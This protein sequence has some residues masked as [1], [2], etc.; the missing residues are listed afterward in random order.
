MSRPRN[1]VPKFS[2]DNT[3]RAF[4]KVG[5]RFISLGRADLPEALLRFAKVLEDHAKGLPVETAQ[6]PAKQRLHNITD[7]L[8]L[9]V[10]KE[11]PRFSPSERHCQAAA[12]RVLRKLFGETPVDQFGPLRL[13][14]VRDAMIA[15]D[16]N[17]TDSDGN[18][19]HRKPWA[20]DTVNRQVKRLQ[21]IFRWGVS[22]EIVPESMATALGTLRVLKEGETAAAE[23]I[24][25]SAVTEA[26]IEA[27]RAQLKPIYRDVVDLLLLTGA[28]PG[29]ILGLTSGMID[30]RGDEWVVEL[31]NHKN[32][33]KKKARYLIFNREAQAI[34]LRRLKADPAARLFPMRRDTFSTA[35]KRACVRAKIEPFCP[36]R[37][38]HTAIT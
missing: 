11:F 15:G 38:R 6:A 26:D 19:D 30:R 35:L 21:A 10:T 37:L 33:H 27:G 24:P 32:R 5:G 7:L 3:G 14:V 20:R 1:S 17:G 31:K 22:F 29:E 9:Y 16:P 8:Y 25:R 13:R 4:T 34:L 23:S 28:R 2:I 12:I 18:P 36:H